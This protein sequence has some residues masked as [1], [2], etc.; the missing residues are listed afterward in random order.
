MRTATERLITT[1]HNAY[2]K[3]AL[4]SSVDD[5]GSPLDREHDVSDI[6]QESRLAMLRDVADFLTGLPTVDL[7]D[8][9]EEL[10]A[11]GIGHDFWL[12]RNRHGA[13]FW[14]R[15]LGALGDRLTDAAQAY[16]E[17]YLYVGDD[18]RVYVD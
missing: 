12:I 15:E 1:A 16:G 14:D 10:G 3:T 17:S 2:M 6:A 11:A 9:L 4:W 18:G 13:G 7:A 8:A 5:D